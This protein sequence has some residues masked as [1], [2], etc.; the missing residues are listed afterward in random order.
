MSTRHHTRSRQGQ[1]APAR[2]LTLDDLNGD[3]RRIYKIL[4]NANG[5]LT[6][7]EIARRA[8]KLRPNIYTA[9]YRTRNALRRLVREHLVES[10]ARGTYRLPPKAVTGSG[11]V[12]GA[13]PGTQEAA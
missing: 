5:P 12:S 2:N 13:V 6:I 10:V 3:E 8:Y 7:R 11:A 9:E 1:H 4:R